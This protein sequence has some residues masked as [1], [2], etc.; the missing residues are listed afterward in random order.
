MVYRIRGGICFAL[1]VC[2][3]FGLLICWL[4]KL[5]PDLSA[6][7][8]AIGLVGVPFVM[9]FGLIGG[10]LITGKIIDRYGRRMQREKKSTDSPPSP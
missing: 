1:I 6:G 7:D 5:P 3:L 10:Y 9:L 4:M 8:T 2:S